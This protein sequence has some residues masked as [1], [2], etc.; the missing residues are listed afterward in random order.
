MDEIKVVCY[1][2]NKNKD[3]QEYYQ[4]YEV[5]YHENMSLLEIL[6]YISENID[7]TLAYPKHAICYQGICGECT[8]KMNDKPVLPC[9][10]SP[11]SSII[12]IEPLKKEEVIRDLVTYR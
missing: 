1:R 11:K 5:P 3:P 2:Y 12:I 10:E 9:L 8:I 7:P 4:V 6:T